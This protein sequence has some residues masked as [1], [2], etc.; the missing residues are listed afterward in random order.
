MR[1]NGKKY[2][3]HRARQL[4]AEGYR[5][6]G[7]FHE[8][9]KITTRVYI[10]GPDDTKYQA[11]YLSEYFRGKGLFR[12]QLAQEDLPVIT[13]RECGLESFYLYH[14]IPHK[15]AAHHTQWDEYQLISEF[16]NNKKARRSSVPYMN[17]IDEGLG[18]L[19]EIGASEWAMKAF[20]LHPIFQM[21]Q[22]LANNR[23]FFE[24]L[25]PRSLA[26]A[27]EYR[28]VANAYLSA[29]KID[30]LED[31]ALSPLKDVNDMLIADK[32][33]NYKDFLKHHSE[34]PRSV[35]LDGYFNHWFKRLGVSYESLSGVLDP[36]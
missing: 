16:Y 24:K 1:D 5:W 36:Y 4:L 14:D 21:D 32:V 22:D 35:Q 8:H 3:R 9:K 7:V 20:C 13:T 6:N 34:H 31:I 18:I 26:L 33:Q 27:M 17:H 15:L 11:V 23:V 28:N 12:E 30:A 19:F 2:L 29:R 10:T 25:N